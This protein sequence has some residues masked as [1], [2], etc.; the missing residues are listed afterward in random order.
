M[1]AKLYMG[2]SFEMTGHTA[3]TLGEILQSL[4][5]HTMVLKCIPSCAT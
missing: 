3:I 4:L 2:D 1:L 5:I